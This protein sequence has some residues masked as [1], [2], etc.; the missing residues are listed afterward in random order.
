MEQP[1][2][3]VVC[4]ESVSKYTCPKCLVDY[5]SLKC[6]KT[7][8]TNCTNKFYDDQFSQLLRTQ[9]VSEEDKNETMRILRRFE[10]SE[11][12]QFDFSRDSHSDKPI[13]EL[14]RD[15]SIIQSFEAALREGRIS[16]PIKEYHPFWMTVTPLIIESE[17][18]QLSHSTEMMQISPHPLL[19][20]HAT[21]LLFCYCYLSRL[22]NGQLFSE[23]SSNED[24]TD[25]SDDDSDSEKHDDSTEE[26]TLSAADDNDMIRDAVPIL[27]R[28]STVL[29]PLP[30]QAP[31]SP[32]QA[33]SI[34]PPSTVREALTLAM[35]HAHADSTRRSVLI[36]PSSPLAT[37]IPPHHPLNT[38]QFNLLC[39]SDLVGLVS[40]PFFIVTSLLHLQQFLATAVQ[41]QESSVNPAETPDEHKR[42]SKFKQKLVAMEKKLTFFVVWAQTRLIGEGRTRKEMNRGTDLFLTLQREIRDEV[43]GF[44]ATKAPD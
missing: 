6:Y 37:Q 19:Y 3:C 24:T 33:V 20:T 1:R 30:T 32:D 17:P 28:L 5:C 18:H 7:H 29:N 38:T 15:P 14:L 22:Y 36:P 11:D 13:Q 9:K 42:S 21:D 4:R 23:G 43:D 16:T 44:L 39:C 27:L 26:D 31:P 10:E 12:S 34:P 25:G 41:I 8:N 40:S 2:Y 35:Q